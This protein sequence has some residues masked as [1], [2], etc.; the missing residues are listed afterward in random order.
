MLERPYLFD[1]HLLFNVKIFESFGS[2]YPPFLSEGIENY[3]ILDTSWNE[4]PGSNIKSEHILL[5]FDF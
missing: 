2:N 3:G 5:W 4:R 1:A